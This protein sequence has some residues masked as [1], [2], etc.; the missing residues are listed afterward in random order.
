MGC[1]KRISGKVTAVP[2]VAEMKVDLKAK[3]LW[4]VHKQGVTPSPRALWEAIE[5]T[6]HTPTR[7]E[8]PAGTYTVKPEK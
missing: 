8:S 6:D 5:Q 4:A 3:T 2:G 7:M 1:A